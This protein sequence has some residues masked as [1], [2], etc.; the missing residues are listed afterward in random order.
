MTALGDP[1]TLRDESPNPNVHKFL[2]R[3]EEG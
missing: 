1:K 3:G 2:T